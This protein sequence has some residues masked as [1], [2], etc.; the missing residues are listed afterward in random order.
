MLNKV[1]LIGRV[2]KD[3]QVKQFSN[4][5]SIVEFSIAT[6]DSYKDKE[7]NKVEQTDWH[8]IKS[9]FKSLNS[10]IEKYVK[11]GMQVYV[12]GKIKTRSYDDKDG[13]KRYVTEIVADK[14]L[15]L[16]RPEVDAVETQDTASDDEKTNNDLPF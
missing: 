12:E 14:V 3:P 2:G 13:N 16:S 10:T 1:T 8:N 5:N 7:G 11:K 15:F 9:T 6:D 4:G